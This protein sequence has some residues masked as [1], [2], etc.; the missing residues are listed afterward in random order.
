MILSVY[1]EDEIACLSLT[2]EYYHR[3][4]ARAKEIPQGFGLRKQISCLSR[5]WLL[6]SSDGSKVGSSWM[7]VLKLTTESLFFVCLF[8]LI[9]HSLPNKCAWECTVS[10][11]WPWDLDSEPL[12]ICV[13]EQSVVLGLV[14]VRK[15]WPWGLWVWTSYVPGALICEP[16]T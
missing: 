9:L 1:Y 15:L 8:V 14:G 16:W 7:M 12:G 5:S 6:Q 13:C 3:P 2:E 10:Q 4:R 11:M